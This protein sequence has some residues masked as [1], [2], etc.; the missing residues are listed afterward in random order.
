M[1]VTTKIIPPK[2]KT[3]KLV[4]S[5]YLVLFLKKMQTQNTKF[6]RLNKPKYSKSCIENS[7]TLFTFDILDFISEIYSLFFYCTCL[8]SRQCIHLM[9]RKVITKKTKGIACKAMKMLKLLDNMNW[10]KLNPLY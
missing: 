2:A 4:N 7:L 5:V 1:K 9:I 3:P 8:V 10:S 6:A